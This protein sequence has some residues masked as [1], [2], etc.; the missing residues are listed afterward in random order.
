MTP[1]S[2]NV[3][4]TGAAGGMCRGINARLA[5]AGHTVL[6][7]DLNLEAAQAAADQITAA[8]G[9]AHPFELDVTSDDS[10][11]RLLAEVQES[12]GDIQALVNAAGIL[13]RKYLADHEGGSFER[14]IDINLNGPFRMIRAFAPQL[15]EQ[16]WGRIINIS[17]IAGTTGYH[18]PSYAASKAGLS[19]LTRS[20]LVDFWGTGV[21]VN[22]VCPGVVD[23]SMVIQEVRDQV[24]RK[25]PTEQIVQPEEIGAMITFLLSEDA[26][27]INGADLVIDG[28]ATQVFSLFDR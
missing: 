18:Y 23:T 19:N 7:A 2:L 27:N 15:V 6:C 1:T 14:A 22:S 21:T 5:E 9:S 24:K 4:V 8:D 3:L 10:V 26:K 13:D 25:V 28:G 17:S 11:E 20:L 12:V 16:G